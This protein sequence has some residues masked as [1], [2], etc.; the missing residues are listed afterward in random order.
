MINL[1]FVLLIRR[2]NMY[3]GRTKII[4]DLTSNHIGDIRIIEAMVK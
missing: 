3:T 2:Y 1:I 4:V